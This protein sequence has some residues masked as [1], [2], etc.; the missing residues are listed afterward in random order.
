VQAPGSV[1]RYA[2]LQRPNGLR[3]RAESTNATETDLLPGDPVLLSDGQLTRIVSEPWWGLRLPGTFFTDG[4]HLS[5]YI[6]LSLALPTYPTP[7]P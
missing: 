4:G 2:E 7:S 6:D 5:A 3:V 1:T